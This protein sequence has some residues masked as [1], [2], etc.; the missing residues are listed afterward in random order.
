MR[1][2]DREVF[3]MLDAESEEIREVYRVLRQLGLHDY[4]IGIG[5]ELDSFIK[6]LESP[7]G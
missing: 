3:R 4:G 5:A 6:E 1:L 7:S 2:I